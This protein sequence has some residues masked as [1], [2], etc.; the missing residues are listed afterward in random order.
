MLMNTVA[1]TPSFIRNNEC[2]STHTAI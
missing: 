2:P 1:L